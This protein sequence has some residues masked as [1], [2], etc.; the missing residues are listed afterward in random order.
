MVG[1]G[2]RSRNHQIIA[3]SFQRR[4]HYLPFEPLHIS[5]LFIIHGY[6][7]RRGIRMA[8]DHQRRREGPRLGGVVTNIFHLYPRLLHYFS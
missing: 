3:L 7:S 6:V 5:H 2:N 1:N 4:K 8:A